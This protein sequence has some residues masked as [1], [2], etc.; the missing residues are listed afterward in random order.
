MRSEIEIFCKNVKLLRENNHLTKKEMAKICNIGTKS[1]SM[2]EKGILP[3][4]LSAS[5]LFSLNEH[6]NIPL[7][8]LFK[9]L[10]SVNIS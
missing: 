7:K 1:L 8:D 3:E 10:E 4:R 2:L 6:F 5:I 9:P